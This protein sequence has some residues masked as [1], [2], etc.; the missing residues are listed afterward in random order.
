[1]PDTG[2]GNPYLDVVIRTGLSH[3]RNVL[4][5]QSGDAVIAIGGSHGTLSEIAFALKLNRPV[6]GIGSWAIPGVVACAGPEDAVRRARLLFSQ[7]EQ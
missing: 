5:V 1:V 2:N 7:P 6:L 3:A 4:V